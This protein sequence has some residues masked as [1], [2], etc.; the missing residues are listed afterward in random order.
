MRNLFIL[1]ML[2]CSPMALASDN[3]RLISVT[4]VAEKSFQPD[5]VRINLNVWGKG[6]SAKAAQVN[7]QKN[8]ET[9]K[10]GLDSFKIKKE[11]VRTLSYELSP[12]YVYDPKTNKNNI[13]G[14]NVNQGITVVL[15]KVE[16][17]GSFVDALSN[18]SKQF[19][20]GITVN[21][22]NFDIEK[23]SEEERALLEDAVKSAEAQ[24]DMLA[25]AAKVKMKGVY[26]LSP[27]SSNRP[28]PMYQADALMVGGR[29]K[30][31]ATELLSG[32]VKVEA[33]VSAD[34]LID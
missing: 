13:A 5:I 7:N 4:G 24:A 30:G 14:Y 8:F 3:V 18:D 1:S 12:E 15:R 6:S 28:M 23:R 29:A 17:A 22:L 25:R 2:F 9:L 19:I 33:S 32:Q 16:E 21:S 10:K 27:L 34:Y 20:G 26:R 31:A 11:D